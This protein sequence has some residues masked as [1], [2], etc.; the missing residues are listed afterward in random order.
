MTPELTGTLATASSLRFR[1]GGGGGLRYRGGTTYLVGATVVV[2]LVSGGG[3]G[4]EGGSASE[5]AASLALVRRLSPGAL[6]GPECGVGGA[7]VSERANG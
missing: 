2:V 5:G 1:G 3:R 4:R 6:A 7:A